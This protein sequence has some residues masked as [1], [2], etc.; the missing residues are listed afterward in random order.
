MQPHYSV[1]E[2]VDGRHTHNLKGNYSAEDTVNETTIY[3][4]EY[5]IFRLRMKAQL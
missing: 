1:F 4:F 5:T 2:D 3:I